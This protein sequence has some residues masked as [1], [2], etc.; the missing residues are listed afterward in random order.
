[1]NRKIAQVE[2]DVRRMKL[3]SS[4]IP[5]NDKFMPDVYLGDTRDLSSIEFEKR[6][7]IIIITSPPYANR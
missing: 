6:P 7:T 2:K 3:L 4:D 5:R 1:M